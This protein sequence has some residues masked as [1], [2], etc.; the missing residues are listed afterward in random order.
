MRRVLPLLWWMAMCTLPLHSYSR[1]F[2]YHSTPTITTNLNFLQAA[3]SGKVIDDTGSGM[4]GVNVIIKGTSNGTTT[5]ANGVY[6]LTPTGDQSAGILVFSFIGYQAQEQPINNRTSI[7]VTM[8]PDV[9]QLSEVVVVG[10]GTQEKRDVTA[11]I[12]TVTG[13]AITKIPTNNAMDAMKGQIAGVDIL[14]NGGRPGEAP[15]IRVR[16]RRS[17]TASN[18]PLFVIDGIPMTAGIESINDFSTADI[19]SVEVL[20]DAASQ[21][22]YGSRGSNGVILITTRRGEPGKTS[23]NFSTSYGVTEPFRTIPMMNGQQ[24]AD[25]KREANRVG[26]N[27]Q[28]GRAAWGDV[29]S[30]IPAD[31]AVFNDAVELNSVQNGL[32]TDWQDLIYQNGSQLNQNLSV[33]GGT[34]KTYLRIGFN[35]FQE[36]GLVEGVDFKRYTG[37]INLDHR[38]SDRFKVGVSSIF[39]N[40]KQNFGSGSVIPEAVNQSPLGLPYDAQGNIIFLPISDGIRSNPLSELVPGKRVDERKTSRVFASVFAEATIVE[41]LQYKFLIGQ[42]LWNRERGVFEGQFTNTR[43]NGTPYAQLEKLQE[44]GYTLENLLT[45][46]KSFGEHSLGL[47]FLHSVAEQEYSYSQTAAQNIPFE[48]ALWHNLGLGTITSY[49]TGLAEYQ[50]LSYMGRVNYSYKG[51]YLFQASMRWDG[52]SRLAEGNK[53]NSFPGVSVGWRMKD[54]GFMADVAAVSELKLRASYGKVGNTSVAPYGTQDLLALTVYDWNNTDAR[55]FRLD[56]LASPN[57]SWEVAESFDVGVDFGFFNGRLNGYVDYYTT[58][59]G[60]SLLLNRALPPTSGYA[61]ILQNIGGTETKGYE[62]TLSSTILDRPNSL[63][64]TAEFNFG[65]LKEKIIDL[66]L[67]GPNGEKVNDVGNN[68]FI[69][70]PVRVFY[71]YEKLGIWQADEKD[72]AAVY[73]QFPGE[74]KVADLN[75]DGRIDLTN[76]RKVLGN[77]VP[78]AYG[79]LKNKFEFKGFD[80]E[81]FF[82]YRLGFMIRSQFS[83]GQATMQARYNNLVVDY[84]TIDNPTNEYPRP[85][86]NQENIQYGS[87][88]QYMDG[89]FV[90]LRNVTLG[91]SLPANLTEKLHM[92]KLRV[93]VTAQNPYTWSKYKLFDPERAGDVTS[94]EMPSYRMLLGGVEIKF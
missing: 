17:L 35:N 39:S 56:R 26:A 82:Y 7:D 6:R 27:G 70:E 48:A 43:K 59:T 64:W 33:S 38:I 65:S 13:E 83:N 29:G 78:K 24:F 22:V 41:G 61:F 80:L 75:G 91:Y 51:K 28:S 46:N 62:I 37:R 21:A 45:Y 1:D 89:G 55:G 68:W 57:L 60:T 72:A 71:D 92:T 14:Q 23:V 4:P 2:T 32:S 63:K 73:G 93:F 66:A 87:S 30:S 34:D 20:K 16:G 69:G 18:D 84:W 9:E 36:D 50:L 52:S 76:D 94:G 44:W 25:M 81:V 86:K 5:D 12:S 67:K 40:S 11:S 74:I 85:N 3:I 49:N 15:T 79:G 31:A 8:V 19:A 88:L 77:D 10:Y 54:E 58:T 47:T 53:W 90:K 42:D